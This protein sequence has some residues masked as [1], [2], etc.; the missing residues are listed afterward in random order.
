MAV[1]HTEPITIE[2]PAPTTLAQQREGYRRKLIEARS[3][4]VNG[5]ESLKEI[6][7]RFNVNVSDLTRKC[8]KEGWKAMRAEARSKLE[9]R[10]EQRFSK[11]K[12]I[13]Q[14]DFIADT[15]DMV[16][17]LSG[18]IH[19]E[20][21]RQ[22]DNIPDTL[23]NFPSTADLTRVAKSIELFVKVGRD[24]YAIKSPIPNIDDPKGK[25][26]DWEVQPIEDAE[27]VPPDTFAIEAPKTP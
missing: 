7:V 8:N 19:R 15:G 4:F 13:L 18:L 17:K 20:L 5:S 27:V 14:R 25:L 11:R 24:L 26:A 3:V 9:R 22:R 12:E 6:A 2:I 1:K 23:G 16:E 10:A 21:D